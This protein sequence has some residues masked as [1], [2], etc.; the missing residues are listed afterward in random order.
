MFSGILCNVTQCYVLGACKPLI[1]KQCYKVTLLRRFESLEI[2]GDVEGNTG[3]KR[4][5]KMGNY[6]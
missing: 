5:E 1:L 2:F 6:L 3:G 4:D